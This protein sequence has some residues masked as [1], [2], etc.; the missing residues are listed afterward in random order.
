MVNEILTGPLGFSVSPATDH[1]AA[2][3]K[4]TWVPTRCSGAMPRPIS[5]RQAATM[6]FRPPLRLPRRI[7]RFGRAREGVTAVEFAMV[8]PIFFALLLAIFETAFA[9]L[10]S[11]L[12]ETATVDASRLILTGQA[13]TQKMTKDTF[14]E[15]VCSML[16]PFI[17]C[18]G[19][20]YIDVQKLTSYDIDNATE[21]DLDPS[22]FKF[23]TGGPEDIVMVRIYYKWT[24]LIPSVMKNFGLDLSNQSDGS[25]LETATMVF[26]NEP[27]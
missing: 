4:K 20:V 6:R 15:A 5:P 8:A 13:Q 17:D 24:G 18:S 19:K 12:I 27:Y 9:M 22:G 1:Q 16:P 26:R 21:G 14:K 2:A 23:I 25:T 11:Q 10:S 7:A 3:L